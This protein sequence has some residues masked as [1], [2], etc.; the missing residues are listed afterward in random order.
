ME[1]TDASIQSVRIIAD[2]DSAF[3]QFGLSC[4]EYL[5]TCYPKSIGMNLACPQIPLVEH[6][7]HD[8]SLPTLM[9]LANIFHSE[10]ALNEST[11]TCQFFILPPDVCDNKL[12]QSALAAVW[13]DSLT[14]RPES[15]FIISCPYLTIDG[16]SYYSPI[17]PASHSVTP[18]DR[19]YMKNVANPVELS[20]DSEIIAGYVDQSSVRSLLETLPR[21]ISRF[22]RDFRAIWDTQIETDEWTEIK[23]TIANL[24]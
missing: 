21:T 16:K 3:S 14:V 5:R 17:D 2:S 6:W 19:P 12:H 8:H 11:R 15:D 7:S 10:I 13:L 1:A 4:S 22:Q 23:D 18:R 24:L 20:V 9:N